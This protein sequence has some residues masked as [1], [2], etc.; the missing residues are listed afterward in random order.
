M[1]GQAVPAGSETGLL[2]P[3]GA[4]DTGHLSGALGDRSKRFIHA[5]L[6]R[7]LLRLRLILV[8]QLVVCHSHP[9]LI[10][11]RLHHPVLILD[12]QLAQYWLG[13]QVS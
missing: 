12:G 4:L 11:F 6:L 9:G 1:L 8:F 10:L 13:L 5:L 2:Q 3:V 7:N